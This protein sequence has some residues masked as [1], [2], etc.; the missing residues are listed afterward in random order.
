MTS[1]L[2]IMP[3][4]PRPARQPI[5]RENAEALLRGSD[6]HFHQFAQNV[7]AVFWVLDPIQRQMLYLSPA[8]ERIWGRDHDSLFQSAEAWFDY[9]HPDD[10]AHVMEARAELAVC[11]CDHTYRIVR[12]DGDV[13]WIRDRG[14]PIRDPD[15]K[16]YR[17]L[18][19]AEDI[20]QHKRHEQELEVLSRLGNSLNIASTAAEAANIIV[21]AAY[22]LFKWDCATLDLYDPDTDL[23]TALITLD[24]IEGQRVSVQPTFHRDSPSPRARN[25]LVGGAQLVLRK[26]HEGADKS[27][28]MFG[29]KSKPSKSL[30]LVPMRLGRNTVGI[31][32]MQ[33]YRLNAYNKVDLELLQLFGD[34]AAGALNRIRAEERRREVEERL[35]EQ[36]ALLEL[37][38]DAIIVQSLDD[39]IIYWNKGAERLYGWSRAEAMCKKSIEMH[40]DQAKYRQILETVTTQGEW[41]GELT[42]VTKDGREVMVLSRGT[43]ILGQDQKPK[44]VLTINSDVT[45]QRKLEGQMLRAQRMESIGTLAGGIAHDLNN[46]LA[47]ILMGVQILRDN[48]KTPREKAILDTLESSSQRGADLV[49]QVLTFARGV[50]G[51]RAA[52]DVRHLAKEIEKVI[53]DTFPKNVDFDLHSAKDLW[54]VDADPTHI[55]QVLMNL[56]V[57]ARD[58]MPQ[59][60]KL[61]VDLSN[62]IIDGGYAKMH[63]DGAPGP[64][65]VMT[66]TDTGSGITPEVQEKMFDPFFTTKELGKGT[67]LGLATVLTIVK[68]HQGFINVYSEL[69]KG[70]TFKVY[71]PANPSRESAAQMIAE[72]SSLPHGRGEIVMVVDDEENIRSITSQTLEC[73]GYRV[74]CAANGAEAV[75]LYAQHRASIAVVLTDMMMPVMDGPAT[76]VALQAI[77]PQVKI[78][79]SS[80]LVANDGRSRDSAVGLRYFVPKPY[81]AE[82]LLNVLRQI[83][84]ETPP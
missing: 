9:V 13:R 25:V 32:S 1:V 29:D 14:Y 24:T 22:E 23:I 80:G 75:A 17:L 78:I 2:T 60:G 46:V 40:K 81:T 3:P 28:R 20:T 44:A 57:N 45:H 15:G 33:S 6:E 4:T 62:G 12:P 66:V 65:V 37:T 69:G 11:G 48:A 36:A 79:G 64:Y 59:G 74:L 47:P 34:H 73:F 82:R 38:P 31:L 72:Q 70:S 53:H 83:L 68:G 19:I 26:E 67:G 41:S 54:T 16:V 61:S 51:R 30:M 56:C 63:P 71:L 27:S 10:R 49:R 84:T 50:E 43:L 76:I 77:N 35:A 42:K 5:T 21:D 52:V 58:A 55:H 39:R 7:N 8:F 18:G